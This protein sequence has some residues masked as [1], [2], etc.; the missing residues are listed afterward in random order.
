[1]VEPLTLYGAPTCEDTALVRHRLRVL[2]APFIEI[3]VE[4]D[5]DASRLVEQLN[6]GAR[7]TPTLTL[8]GQP[9]H[10]A[11]P[12]IEQLQ[13]WLAA[14]RI[15]FTLP[16]GL[17]YHGELASRP[18]PDFALAGH[19]AT[20]FRLS[21]L[22]GRHKAVIF[23]A[24]DHRCLVC[25]GYAKQLASLRAALTETD[26]VLISVLQAHE[27]QARTWAEEFAAGHIVLADPDGA[28]KQRLA[29]YVNA[30]RAGVLVLLLD[31]YT[32]PRTRIQAADAGGLLAPHELAEWLY[33]LD[34]E[35]AE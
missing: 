8:A 27:E 30:D 6:G 34:R 32:A 18:L 35:C 20:P 15:S 3:N 2:G 29:A 9:G 5:A 10:L 4:R 28:V 21:N 25:A 7:I 26:A 23:F 14:A 13:D 33:Y 12:T 19:P 22:R 1:M 31:R 16:R 17:D 24:H 11:E